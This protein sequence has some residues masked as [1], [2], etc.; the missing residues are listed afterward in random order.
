MEIRNSK[1]EMPLFKVKG[2]K[3]IFAVQIKL[4]GKCGVVG[5]N[6]MEKI[7]L[8][9]ICNPKQWKTIP[10]SELL[11]NGYPVYGA[12]GIIGYYSEFNHKNP[13]ITVTCRGATCGTINITVP[14]SY[15][16]GNAMCLDDMRSDIYMEYLYYCL[17]HYNFNNVIS[18]SAQPQI[19][20]QGMEKIYV[21]IGSHNEQMDI[22]DKLKKV[23]NVIGLRKRELKQLDT[24]VKSRF[25]EMFGD[26]IT[27][28]YN[29]KIR[30]LGDVA[31]IGSSHRVFTTEFVE[32]GIPF[33][34]GTE[35]GELANGIE[36][37]E[38]YY[39]SEEHYN[40]LTKDNTKPRIGDLLMPSICNKGQIWMVDTDRP[41]YYKDGRVLCISPNRDIFNSKYLEY[42]MRIKTLVEYPKLGS[43]ST[44]AEF[45]IFLLKDM[46]VLV[47][48][49]NVQNQFADFVASV[50]KSKSKI[51]KSLEETQLLFDSLMQKYFG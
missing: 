31:F 28:K 22:V 26:I 24:L 50:D 34:R 38:P 10:T 8:T 40:K 35:I 4:Q 5:E 36:P 39:I 45:K 11:E 30:K 20:R 27:G 15:V 42:F 44:F 21:T 29:Y 32:S 48:P 49:R 6:R 14:K 51:Q 41:F 37:S 23:E 12:N 46:D 43:G 3:F 2:E 19:T 16:T 33:Y 47:P 9:D 13:V 1:T 17:K 7:K 18:G 25:V